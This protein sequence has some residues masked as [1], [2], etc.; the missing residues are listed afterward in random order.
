MSAPIA[1][2]VKSYVSSSVDV[3]R[4]MPDTPEQV[5]FLLA[6]SIGEV[7]DDRADLFYVTVATPEGARK[8]QRRVTPTRNG[9]LILAEYS[10]AALKARIEEI[11]E[12][13]RAPSW[14][15]SVRLLERHF[16]YEYSDYVP[17]E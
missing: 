15:E 8:H 10:P 5:Y 3:A 12:R 2:E 1:L 11:V 6:I 16:E 17:D 14:G 7:G 4:W 9:P 13:C